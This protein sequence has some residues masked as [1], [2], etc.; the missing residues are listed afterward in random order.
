MV[1]LVLVL[2]VV[3]LVILDGVTDVVGVVGVVVVVVVGVF[4]LSGPNPCRVEVR[5]DR[6]HYRS[7]GVLSFFAIYFLTYWKRL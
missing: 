5:S 3:I 7:F 1:V 2:V 6:I 4:S